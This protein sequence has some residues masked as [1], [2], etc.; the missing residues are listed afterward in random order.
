MDI[1][2]DAG[3]YL[4]GNGGGLPPG[5][6]LQGGR[7]VGTPTVPGAYQFTLCNA[8][9]CTTHV[10]VVSVRGQEGSWQLVSGEIPPGLTLQPDGRLTGVPTVSG[11][12]TFVITDGVVTRV[13]TLT[14]LPA[15][16]TYGFE[17]VVLELNRSALLARRSSWPPARGWMGS[18][19]SGTGRAVGVFYGADSNK[20]EVSPVLESWRILPED[21]LARDWVFSG[22]PASAGGRLSV[23]GQQ[24][25]LSGVAVQYLR[26]GAT[27]IKRSLVTQ[28][29][30][31]V[32]GEF[33]TPLNFSG[34]LRVDFYSVL[35][36]EMVLLRFA[37]LRIRYLPLALIN[38]ASFRAGTALNWS[39]SLD[40]GS[41][42]NGA[43]DIPAYGAH[44]IYDVTWDSL[45]AGVEMFLEIK[46]G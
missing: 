22:S 15:G 5:L 4:K 9:R 35:G 11:T 31:R 32:L 24:R 8:V 33:F 39:A 44:T 23:A 13:V 10:F 40:A 41:Y 17:D 1:V 16:A 25:V 37:G 46:I 43:I 3:S 38:Q 6:L 18:R 12:Y 19:P 34:A 28:G 20:A 26:Q 14:V 45:P 29:S 7:I 21:M 30:G 2:V 42:Y 27:V 36:G